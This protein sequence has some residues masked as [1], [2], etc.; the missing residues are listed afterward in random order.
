MNRSTAWFLSRLV[1]FRPHLWGL[2]IGSITALGLVNMIPGLIVREFF[3]RL[4]GSAPAN[5]GLATLVVLLLAASLGS[6]TFL[7]GCQLTNAPFMLTAAALLQK[8]MLARVLQLPGAA[9][10]PSSSGE[11]I[12]RFPDD[13]DEITGSLIDFNDLIAFGLFAL[14]AFI[15]MLHINVLI[16]VGVFLPIVAVVAGVMLAGRRIERYRKASREATGDITGFLGEVFGAV[17]AVQVANAETRVVEYFRR[18]NAARLRFTIR[19]RL[20]DQMMQSL[21]WN[22]V[23]LGTGLMLLIA[24]GAI[25]SGAFTVGDFALFTFYLGWITEF[26]TV[27]GHFLTRYRQDGVSIGRM[28]TLMRAAPEELV[29]P[30]PVYTAGPLPAVP[31]ATKLPVDRLDRLMVHDL[32]YRHPESGRGVEGVTLCLERGSFTVV[33]G[34]VG[35]GK[36]TL[37]RTL[38]G[39]LPSEA[40]EVLWN[41]CP[42]PDRATFFTPPRCAY[43]PQAPRLFSET[44]RDNLLMGMPDHAGAVAGALRPAVL[45]DDVA[46][47]ESGLE[48]LVGPK[49][50]RLSGGQIQRAAAARMFVRDA[51]LLVFDDLSSA[52][53]VETENRM[54]QRVF[55]QHEATVLA[56]SH[57]RTALRRADHII[58]LKDGRIEAEGALEELL[59]RS[60]E[61]RRLWQGDDSR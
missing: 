40:G 58:V 17:Q 48:T 14:I 19:D 36:S 12:S 31:V 6:I 13:V 45:E 37:L 9:A 50:V 28:L 42:V 35:A 1:R 30:G 41:G 11:A 52:L 16:T 61:M 20:F 38:L 46:G 55:A 8:N 49:G 54:W 60:E 2:N 7:V 24:G 18:L 44:L 5:L 22:M 53:D 23:N 27:F 15:I 33:T 34:R 59:V 29:R 57:R 4:T 21:F 32:T 25:R 10:L 56:V 43:T 51:E 47:M 39:L 3:N 26:I